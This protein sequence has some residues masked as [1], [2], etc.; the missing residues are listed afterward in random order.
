MKNENNKKVL[1]VNVL[2]GVYNFSVAGFM[3]VVMKKEKWS[4]ITTSKN[5]SSYIMLSLFDNL[6]NALEYAAFTNNYD[7]EIYLFE[8][9]TYVVEGDFLNV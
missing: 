6:F 2:W 9:F 5:S 7:E 8:W 3:V 1:S 4:V